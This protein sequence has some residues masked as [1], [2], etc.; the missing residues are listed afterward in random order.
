MQ[1]NK[2]CTCLSS[3]LITTCKLQPSLTEWERFQ[4]YEVPVGFTVQAAGKRTKMHLR[5][6]PNSSVYETQENAPQPSLWARSTEPSC[7]LLSARHPHLSS[8]CFI[9]NICSGLGESSWSCALASA[10]SP[11]AVPKSRAAPLCP[12]GGWGHFL[13]PPVLPHT[14]GALFL[15]QSSRNMPWY[16]QGAEWHHRSFEWLDTFSGAELFVNLATNTVVMRGGVTSSRKQFWPSTSL[17]R[18]EVASGLSLTTLNATKA[19]KILFFTSKI[20]IPPFH[21]MPPVSTA[22]KLDL[23]SLLFSTQS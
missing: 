4:R 2:T 1:N 23:M 15:T 6:P 18:S 8:Q 22:V 20:H 17:Q 12:Q 11:S 21:K 7:C 16:L 9:G 5:A 14:A 13:E 19:P 10:A 3:A